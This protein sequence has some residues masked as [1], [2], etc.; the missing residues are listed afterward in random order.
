MDLHEYLLCFLQGTTEITVSVVIA[1]QR[2]RSKC[3]I[4]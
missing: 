2:G 1:A 3:F 4:D